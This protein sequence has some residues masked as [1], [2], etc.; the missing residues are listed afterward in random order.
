MRA[1]TR[2]DARGAASRARVAPIAS[3]PNVKRPEARLPSL[4]RR[5]LTRRRRDPRARRGAGARAHVFESL[6]VSASGDCTVE[7]V[8][9]L[10]RTVLAALVA[11]G[12]RPSGWEEVLFGSG[13]AAAVPSTIVNAWSQYKAADVLAAGF[14]AVESAGGEFSRT[15][16]HHTTAVTTRSLRGRDVQL[17]TRRA[18]RHVSRDE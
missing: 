4:S 16:S 15:P 1:T 3:S 2:R 13:A 5:P 17:R 7:N 18:A 8:A 14:D 9:S 11:R 12:T 10:E 6:E